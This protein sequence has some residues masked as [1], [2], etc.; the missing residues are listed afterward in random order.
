M[1]A[2]CFY[3][4]E[5]A[6]YAVNF[7]ECLS[8][9]KGIWA[10]KKFELLEW[11]EQIIRDLFGTLKPNGYRQFN[12]AYIEIP[13][14][15]G[16]QL[17]LDTLIPTPEGFTTM[18]AIQ[19]GDTVFD[20]KGNICHVV[21]KSNVDFQEQA[22][23]IIFKDGEIIEAGERHQWCGE[24]TRGKRKKCIMTTGELFRMPLDNGCLRF[25]IAVADA[26]CTSEKTLPIDP[27]LMGYWLGNGNAVKPEITVRTCDVP[28]VLARISLIY[29]DIS[30]WDN[31]G[32]SK[33]FRVPALKKILLKSFHDKVIPPEY[34]RSSYF[35]RIELLQGLMDSDGAISDWKGQAIYTSTEKKLAESVS[36]LLWSLGIK[37][38]ISNAPSTQRTDWNSPSKEC[39][40]VETGE[41][42]YYVKFTAFDDIQIA[43]LSR[44]EKN[45][46]PRNPRTRSHFR[47]IDKIEK[48]ENHG[49]QCIQVDSPSHQYL[50]GRSFLPTHNSELAAAVALLLTC[51]DGE[52]RAEVYGCAA[53]RQ[54]AAIVFDV[55]ADMVR[56]CPA[57]NKRVKILTSQKRIV[58]IPTNSFYQVLSAEAYSKHGFNIHGV[59]FDELHTQP[60]R[61]LFDVM[62][63]GS[64]DARMQPLY[65][66]ITTAG[67]DTNSICY[68]VHQKAKDIIEGRKHDPTFYPV[69]YGADESEDW[70]SPEVWKKANPSLGKTIGIDKVI[71]ACN[72]AKETPGEENSFRQLR[73]NQWVKQAVRW[74]PMEKWDKCKVNFYEDELAGRVCYGGLDLSSTTD[75]TAFVL[76]FPPTAEDEHYYVLPYFWIPEDNIDIRVRRDHV[77]YD[78]WERQGYLKTTEGN[79]VHYGFIENF[80]DELGQ[81]F[82][83][84]EIAFDRWGAVQMSQNLDNLGFTMVQ[85]GQGFRDM[86][87]PT[88]EL[89]KLVLE[90]SLSH[91][92]NPVL[93]WMMD[94]IFIRRDPAGNI[95]PD[96]EKSTEKIDGAVAMIMA[97]DRA[98]RCGCVSSESVYDSREMLIL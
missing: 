79:V 32:D 80:I 71:S 55:A 58:Y 4:K 52:E 8:H 13:K 11:Q 65:F 47:Y 2:D 14:K 26:V 46:I 66:L 57:L 38:A 12:T 60:N 39:G 21:A 56:M 15:N 72:S 94:N 37:N 25:R 75:I 68:E 17:A 19:V 36:E 74:M 40:R 34:L 86:S 85:F 82:N 31:I 59:V 24:Y 35:Q 70:T 29:S 95:K 28:E 73:L 50:V 61:K 97:L 5:S 76:V 81:K 27:Y 91:N 18:G 54:Q 45:Q 43:G 90:T 42:L 53:D 63:K 6:D 23:R 33:V 62:T 77:P 9:T 20:E 7:I 84:K 22:Y 1:S 96:K 89:M 16:K 44:K 64:G 78:V 10:G 87:P 83:I 69:I 88:K 41:T 48:I 98:I 92:G 51:G 3:D 93:R 30:S 49:M 67:T